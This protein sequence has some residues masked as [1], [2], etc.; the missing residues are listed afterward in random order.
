[1]NFQTQATAF[2]NIKPLRNLVLSKAISKSRR[3]SLYLDVVLSVADGETLVT[4][5]EYSEIAPFSDYTNVA[6]QMYSVPPHSLDSTWSYKAL[7]RK[8]DCKKR[9]A[10]VSVS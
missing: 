9:T 8:K 3:C 1:M 7:S 6:V 10:T 2:N 5:S 4:H